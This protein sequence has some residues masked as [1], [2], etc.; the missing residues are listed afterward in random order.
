MSVLRGK[1]LRGVGTLSA[2]KEQKI[3]LISSHESPVLLRSDW[4]LSVMSKYELN[5]FKK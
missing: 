2:V 3:A 1:G 4:G 5:S